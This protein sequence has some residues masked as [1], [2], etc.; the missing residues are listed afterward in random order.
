MPQETPSTE[1]QALYKGLPC[2]K[3]TLKL[4]ESDQERTQ[5]FK[6]R[7]EV[8]NES[9]GVHEASVEFAFDLIP[10]ITA[11]INAMVEFRAFFADI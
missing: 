3:L 5:V 11:E 1:M 4:A 10:D 9:L 6:L 2:G 8:F 7:Y